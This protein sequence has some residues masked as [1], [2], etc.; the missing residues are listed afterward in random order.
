MVAPLL[1][2]HLDSVNANP[3]IKSIIKAIGAEDF[4][5]VLYQGDII[6]CDNLGVF[7]TQ[8]VCFFQPSKLD[9]AF[10][11][12]IENKLFITHILFYLEYLVGKN[13]MQML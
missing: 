3:I 10:L 8:C 13:L 9:T 5:T 6:V 11:K 2:D 7:F 12:K 4:T 1:Q